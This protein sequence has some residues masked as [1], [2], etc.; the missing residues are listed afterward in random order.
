MNEN[1]IVR[2]FG[3]IFF[4]GG[5]VMFSI[6]LTEYANATETVTEK[7]LVPCYDSQHN[8]MLGQLCEED[9]YGDSYKAIFF[10]LFL[11]ALLLI[12]SFELI[13]WEND[14]GVL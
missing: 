12:A 13:F 5:L 11:A 3:V 1:I 14:H 9:S 7:E 10:N 4:L 2:L 6:A 8:R